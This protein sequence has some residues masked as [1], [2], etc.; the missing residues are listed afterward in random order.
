MEKVSKFF[1]FL[2][3]GALTGYHWPMRPIKVTA[4][5]LKTFKL[6]MKVLK[7]SS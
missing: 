1:F 7:I 4:Q 3:A 5:I 2:M 6:N